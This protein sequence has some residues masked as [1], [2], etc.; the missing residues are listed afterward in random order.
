M[1]SCCRNTCSRY[2]PCCIFRIIGI[3]GALFAVALGIVLGVTL[4]NTF[5]PILA[6]I[7]VFAVIMLILI[8]LGLIYAYCQRE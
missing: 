7:I 2:S 1:D 3:L 4:F 8:I 6:S 5:E